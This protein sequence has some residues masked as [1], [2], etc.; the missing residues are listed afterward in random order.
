MKHEMPK[1]ITIIS[2]LL[3]LLLAYPTKCASLSA[4]NSNAYTFV[5]KS[6]SQITVPLSVHPLSHHFPEW[7]S[8]NHSH[9]HLLG[10]N[11]VIWRGDGMYHCNLPSLSFFGLKIKPSC[12]SIVEQ[13]DP[14]TIT[15]QAEVNSSSST[16]DDF[17]HIL[18]AT[19]KDITEKERVCLKVTIQESVLQVDSS[20][21][22]MGTVLESITELCKLH[23]GNRI[24]CTRQQDSWILSSDLEL[25]L[26]LFLGT[27]SNGKPK[28]LPPGF[29]SIGERILRKTCE[30]RVQDNLNRIKAGFEDY[31][32]Q[33]QESEEKALMSPFMPP[34]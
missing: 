25:H 17:K 15:K 7:L 31:L 32:V 11:D 24:T 10:T 16:S 21:E 34:K 30:K 13:E 8:S 23:G 4:S 3:L 28:F 2:L 5:G 1:L 29:R 22:S 26:H 33:L 27:N 14:E 9:H 6:S 19:N 20:S 18:L 12:V